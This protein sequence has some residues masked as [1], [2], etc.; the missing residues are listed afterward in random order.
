MGRLGNWAMGRRREANKLTWE[1][2]C[3]HRRD[4]GADSACLEASLH[5]SV[6]GGDRG[7]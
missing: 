3:F 4:G 1:R 7:R 2:A 6:T 5:L